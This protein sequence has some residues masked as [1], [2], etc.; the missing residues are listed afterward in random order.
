MTK[1]GTTPLIAAAGKNKSESVCKDLIKAG[2]DVNYYNKDG[3]TPL[4]AATMEENTKV[5]KLL[6]DHGAYIDFMNSQSESALTYSI[7]WNRM[8]S[9]KLLIGEGANI[10]KA[11][12]YGCGWTPILYAVQEKSQDMVELLIEKGADINIVDKYGDSLA[13]HAIRSN[14][15]KIFEKIVNHP[16]YRETINSAGENTLDVARKIGNSSFVK[17]LER[18]C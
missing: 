17:L 1:D 14:K 4:I 13:I 18:K 15:I 5:M 16:S 2:A 3:W 12:E 9:L 7:V 6:I 8:K 11:D 10:N